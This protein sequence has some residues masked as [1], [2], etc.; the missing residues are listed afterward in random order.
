LDL[1]TLSAIYAQDATSLV[2]AAWFSAITPCFVAALPVKRHCV[3][4]FSADAAKLHK[5]V[6]YAEDLVHESCF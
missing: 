4:A 2:N 3:A 1:T 6:L 5:V